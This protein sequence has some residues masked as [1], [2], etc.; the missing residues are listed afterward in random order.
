MQHSRPAA[1]VLNS[2]LQQ[3]QVLAGQC[4][5]CLTTALSQHRCEK[6]NHMHGS[7]AAQRPIILSYYMSNR[8]KD[9]LITCAHLTVSFASF[10][11]QCV[12]MM[13]RAHSSRG[14]LFHPQACRVLHNISSR[15]LL[16][17]EE[18]REQHNSHL[19]RMQRL[20]RGMSVVRQR[21]IC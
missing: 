19:C 7:N 6:H 15:I 17:G 3:T 5:K 4:R 20:L 9:L 14:S 12:L 13:G 16:A 10:R 1:Q 2:L 18:R 21:R 11:S 8:Y